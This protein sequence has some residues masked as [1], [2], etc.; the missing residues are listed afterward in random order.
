MLQITDRH[1][2]SLQN[3]SRI[4][5]LFMRDFKYMQ[6]FGNQFLAVMQKKVAMVW[7]FVQT[8][9]KEMGYISFLYLKTRTKHVDKKRS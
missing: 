5:G 4:L 1:E 8:G 7:L 2:D 3:L 9:M 6:E